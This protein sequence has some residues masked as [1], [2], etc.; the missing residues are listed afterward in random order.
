M[1]IEVF[2]RYEQKYI[3]DDEAYARLQP[4]LADYM[5]PD[6]YNRGGEA[7]AIANVY[8]DTP[9]S[10]LIRRSLAKPAYKEKLRVRAYGVPGMDDRV[11]VEI[12]KKVRGL[13]NKRRTA[14]TL[15]E[16]YAFLGGRPPERKPYM[17]WQVVGEIQDLLGRYPLRPALYLA[18][19][20]RAWFGDGGHDL[21]VSFDSNIRSRRGDVRLEAGGLGEPLLA[22]GF[23]LMEVKAARSIPIWLSR[24]LADIRAYPTSFSKYGQE[25]TRHVARAVQARRWPALAHAQAQAGAGAQAALAAQALHA[26]QAAHAAHA[27]HVA[28][29]WHL[30]G[31]APRQQAEAAFHQQARAAFAR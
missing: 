8:Y 6:A 5:A 19:D 31:A 26:A 30:A 1:A 11:Y 27:A 22:P 18:Y 28:A 14:M 12:K 23:W 16:A 25:Y 17:N 2:N 9:D 21:R 3:L 13:V 29:P 4:R 20:R 15:R 7:Y 10:Q 24:A